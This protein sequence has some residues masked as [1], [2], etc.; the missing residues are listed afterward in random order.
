MKPILIKDNEDKIVV[1]IENE[2]LYGYRFKKDG[3]VEHIDSRIYDILSMFLLSDNY[4]NLPSENGYK[5]VLDNNTNFKHYFK[6][7]VEDFRMFYLNNGTPAVLYKKHKADKIINDE[8]PREFKANDKSATLEYISLILLLIITLTIGFNEDLIKEKI[9]GTNA[10]KQTSSA[11]VMHEFT[12]DEVKDRIYSSNNLTEKE[13]DFLYNEDYFTDILPYINSNEYANYLFNYRVKNITIESFDEGEYNC[14]GFYS[15]GLFNTISICSSLIDAA[16]YDTLSHEFIHMCEAPD[17]YRMLLEAGAEMVSREY[18]KASF[19]WSYPEEVAIT[20]KLM[21]IIGPDPIREYLFTG[22]DELLRSS[23]NEYLDP[24]ESEL[25]FESLKYEQNVDLSY[26]E[27][28]RNEKID[29]VN[30]LISLMY[31]RKYGGDINDDAL[32]KAITS[33]RIDRFY[34]N[35]KKIDSTETII[36]HT[37]YKKYDVMTALDRG[38]I[39][40]VLY[41][42]YEVGDYEYLPIDIIEE[43]NGTFDK[44]D[45]FIGFN[46]YSDADI[47]VNVND[48]GEL[49]V[50]CPKSIEVKVPSIDEKFAKEKVKTYKKD[51]N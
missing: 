42:N 34:F 3:K 36:Y 26:K 50:T 15:P 30:G 43:K 12:L 1:N 5:V 17:A 40:D 41:Y 27:K 22:S 14:A 46:S 32:I 4:S 2:S 18:F 48:D 24:D 6:D 45:F 16:Y 31:T 37:D 38:I 9:I 19:H 44:D 35:K 10:I 8:V 11:Y 28:E 47:R 49:I 51:L 7:G 13:K 25:F 39:E 21:E 29:A 33:N 20:Q 23:V